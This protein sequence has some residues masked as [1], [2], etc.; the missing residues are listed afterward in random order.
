MTNN[1]E[2]VSQFVAETIFYTEEE[3]EEDRIGGFDEWFIETKLRCVIY[4]KRNLFDQSQ[5]CDQ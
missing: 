5:V 2:T 1:R 3:E 4:W